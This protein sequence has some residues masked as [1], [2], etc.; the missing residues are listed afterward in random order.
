MITDV[1]IKISMICYSCERGFIAYYDMGI[2][3]ECPKCDSEVALAFEDEVE[4]DK[5]Y[6]IL[7]ELLNE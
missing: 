4:L 3:I 5:A 7:E 6:L 2:S 1:Y